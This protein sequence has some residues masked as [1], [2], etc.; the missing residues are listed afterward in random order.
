ME[1][2]FKDTNKKLD[3]II[4]LLVNLDSEKMSVSE[5]APILKAKGFENSQIALI[6]NS[7][8]KYVGEILSRGKS[9]RQSKG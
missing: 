4:W 6:L 2:I 3:V 9:K 8:E 1:E 5:G 7:N